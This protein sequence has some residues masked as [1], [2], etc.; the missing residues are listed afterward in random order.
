MNARFVLV[1]NNF[2]FT[3]VAGEVMF[4]AP[5]VQRLARELGSL[6]V[7]PQ[8]AEGAPLALPGGVELDTSLARAL[9]RG[10]WWAYPLAWA[11]PGFGAEFARAVRTG[12]LDGCARVWRWAAVALVTWRWARARFPAEAPVLFCTYWRGGATLALAR[13]AALRP[14]VAA[15]TRV[16]GHE[17]YEQRW[18]PPFQPWPSMYGDLALT[19]PISRHGLEHLL[20]SGVPGERLWLGRLGTEGAVQAK[21]SD[22]GAIRLV[23]CSW[24]QP[25]KRVPLMAKAVVELARRHAGCSIHWTH[26]GA[27]PEMPRVLEALRAAPPNLHAHLPGEVSHARVLAHYASEAVD[28]FL[29]LSESEGLPVSIQ[30]AAAAGI[31]VLA[32]DVGGVGEI[33]GPDNGLLL[34][35]DPAPDD[36][37]AA[38]EQLCF[39]S[40]AAQRQSLREGSCSRWASEFDAER[41]HTRYARRV[42]ELMDTL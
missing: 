8:S 38:L 19:V 20:A 31:P 9:R 3:H 30:E 22:D 1:T 13:L 14:H 11:W 6:C 15:M 10:R 40:D 29:L 28:L 17:L 34:G 32:T 35:A 12:G 23:S 33:V 16:H 37:V 41:N 24:M 36:V 21:A 26:F 27:G 4:V 42:R 7:A 39:T 2:P 25:V 5:E 18:T